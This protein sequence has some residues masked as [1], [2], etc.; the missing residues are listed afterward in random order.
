MTR[1]RVYSRRTARAEAAEARLAEARK[2]LAPFAAEADKFNPETDPIMGTA[3]FDDADLISATA[4][5][6]DTTVGD[7]RRARTFLSSE[8]PK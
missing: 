4:I 2:V 5:P 1:N 3:G 7:L 6:V 8:E